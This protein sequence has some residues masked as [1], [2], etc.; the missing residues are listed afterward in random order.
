LFGG[1]GTVLAGLLTAVLGTA[2]ALDVLII[3]PRILRYSV[4][5]R[6]STAYLLCSPLRTLLLYVLFKSVLYLNF[7]SS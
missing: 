1:I 4:T 2:L 5:F 6:P 7:I 3:C